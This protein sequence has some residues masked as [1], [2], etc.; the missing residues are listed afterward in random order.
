[1]E[2]IFTL[3]QLIKKLAEQA[4]ET[5]L[6]LIDLVK[7]FDEVIRELLWDVMLKQGVLPKRVSHLKALHNIEKLNNLLTE[8]SK[9]WNLSLELSK[10]ISSSPT[11]FF[12]HGSSLEKLAIFLFPSLQVMHGQV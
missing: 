5:W 11:L 9:Q 7:A 6:L 12:L 2:S 10:V 3:K 1:M 4:L 8:L